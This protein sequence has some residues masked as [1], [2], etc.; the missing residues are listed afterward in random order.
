MRPEL[1]LDAARFEKDWTDPAIAA[2]VDAS[3]KEGESLGV[4]STPAFFVNGRPYFL[5]R[6]VDSFELRFAME[7][8]RAAS[9]CQ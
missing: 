4:G 1:G 3:R 6:T 2:R 9:S 8:A 7:D 5:K